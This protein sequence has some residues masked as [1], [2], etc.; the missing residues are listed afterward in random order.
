[1]KAGRAQGAQIA[2]RVVPAAEADAWSSRLAGLEDDVAAVLAEEKEERALGVAERELR[3]GENLVV[4]ADEIA[5]R[6]KRT[7]FESEK[8]KAEARD[9]GR[10]ELN[11]EIVLGKKGKMK[12]SN[13]EKK[14]LAL[15]DER[16]ETQAW[17]KGKMDGVNAG[18]NARGNP[19]AGSSKSNRKPKSKGNPKARGAPK[20]R[21][22]P[23]SRGGA[24]S[25]G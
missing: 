15:K 3:K 24:R 19:K 1:M 18:R 14:R 6:P 23:K 20:S 10:V 17:K 11:G 21:G 13:K 12:L 2:S 4:H 9:K 16:K 25:R 8:E 22:K 5:A 7:W